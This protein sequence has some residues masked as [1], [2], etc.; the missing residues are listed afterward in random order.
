M[1]SHSVKRLRARAAI[2]SV[3]FFLIAPGTVAGLVPWWLSRWNF[4][5]PFAGYAAVRCLGACLAVGGL[6]VLL[7]SFFRFVFEGLGTPA[8]VMPTEHLVVRGYYRRVRNPMY[9]AVLALIIGQGLWFGSAAVLAYAAG[10]WIVTHL[11]VVCYEEPTLRRSFPQEY[12]AYCAS[13]PRWLPK[14]R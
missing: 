8:P 2:G 10:A 5:R 9:V 12:A 4:H 3:L 13:V 1:P 7:D 14:L 11:F 6:V